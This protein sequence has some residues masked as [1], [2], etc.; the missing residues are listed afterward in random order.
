MITCY[1]PSALCR[2]A[3]ERHLT[4]VFIFITN[5]ARRGREATEPEDEDK[6]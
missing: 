1:Y 5:I 2:N 4:R 3:A 6:G